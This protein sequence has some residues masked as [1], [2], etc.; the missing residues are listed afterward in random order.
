MT[1]ER[2]SIDTSVITVM[3][4]RDGV[5]TCA[6]EDGSA[7]VIEKMPLL[8]AGLRWLAPGQRLVLERG[9][10]VDGGHIIAVRLP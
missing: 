5:A 3:S 2:G 6:F 4:F 8:A 7:V 1:D 9:V 10:A